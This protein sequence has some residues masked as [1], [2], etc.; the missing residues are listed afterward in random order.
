M[1]IACSGQKEEKR[2]A[3]LNGVADSVRRHYAP[4]S[5]DEVFDIRLANV[6]GRPTFQGVTT[7]DAARTE[8]LMQARQ[9]YE[10]V[11]NSI[12]LLLDEA[13]DESECYGVVNVSVANA[14]MGADYA[15]EMGTQVL[16]G[17]PV[18]VLQHANWWRIKTAEGYIAWMNGGSFVRMSQ[19]SFNQWITAEKIIFTDTYGFAYEKAD[20]C[21]RRISDLVFGNMLKYDGEERDFYRVVYPDGR[22]A[23]ISKNQSQRYDDWLASV[24]LTEDRIVE[25][26]FTLQG[27]PYSW[28]GTSTKSVDCSGFVKTIFLMHGVILRRDASQQARTGIPVDVR[29]GYNKLRPGDLMFFGVKADGEKKERVRHVGIYIGNQDFIH[30]SGFVKVSSLDATRANYDATN[31]REFIR[32]TRIIGSVDT[33][34]VWHIAHNPLYQKQD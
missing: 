24:L 20:I 23:Y 19:A 13:V 8:L 21:A 33:E 2:T 12:V 3:E 10:T 11:G 25:K 27:V 6:D 9:I 16:L 32:A 30:S 5:R 1:L 7:V 15:A 26:A 17:A 28:G 18:Q 31:T 34:G 29:D 22:Q 14:R 4:D